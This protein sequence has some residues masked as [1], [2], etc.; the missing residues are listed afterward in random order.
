MF[1]DQTTFLAR[2]IAHPSPHRSPSQAGQNIIVMATVFPYNAD[3]HK[4][5]KPLQSSFGCC[6]LCHIH[7]LSDKISVGI[8][9]L[10]LQRWECHWQ[11]LYSPPSHTHRTL[12]QQLF[13]DVF[14]NFLKPV[15][16]V[17]IDHRVRQLI[18][19]PEKRNNH[20]VKCHL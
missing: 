7:C 3:K 13:P 19:S 11:Q 5:I 20:L 2:K 17:H 14:N 4:T 1:K 9:F 15:M 10:E 12:I 16:L 6:F 8:M 18:S